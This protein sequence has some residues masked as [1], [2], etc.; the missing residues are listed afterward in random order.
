VLCGSLIYYNGG[1]DKRTIERFQKE[2]AVYA[3]FKSPLD[4]LSWVSNLL[5]A[6]RLIGHSI[7][8]STMKYGTL[9]N[10][11]NLIDCPSLYIKNMIS[12]IS[13]ADY[14]ILV[15]SAAD[16]ITDQTIKYIAIAH[17]LDIKNIIVYLSK[18]DLVNDKK[19][20]VALEEEI[21][22]LLAKYDF[23]N[24]S[25]QIFRSPKL[26]KEVYDNQPLNLEKLSYGIDSLPA[27]KRDIDSEPLMLI[28]NAY[29]IRGGIGTVAVGKIIQ[30]TI[31]SGMT[32]EL[33]P[34]YNGAS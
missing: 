3:S 6:E 4:H 5:K 31:K 10:N 28:N 20:L 13:M 8:L 14:I 29:K 19:T 22:K 25:V 32:V 24:E 27:P 9:Y 1:I 23:N 11:I 18:C 33:F 34:L 7:E 16:K 30:G 26:H 2:M 12:G 17:H 21:R 15:I